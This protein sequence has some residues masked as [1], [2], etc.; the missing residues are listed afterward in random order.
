MTVRL[1]VIGRNG[2]LARSLDECS[3]G[4]KGLSLSFFGRPE[5]DLVIPGSAGAAIRAAHPHVVINAA[6]FTAVDLAESAAEETMR[7]N[8][9]GA[10]EVAAAAVE[11][12]AAVIQISTD[13]VFDG[14]STRP[15][16]E[17]D[18]TDPINVYGRSKLAGE[19]AV[20]SANP[21][22]CIVRTSWLFSPFG[23]NFVRTM[24]V[25]GQKRDV[26]KVVDDQRGNPTSALDLAQALL[27]IV[28]MLARNEQG[29]FGTW[30]LTGESA[31]SWC[32][33]AD[34]VQQRC[35]ARGLNA[36]QVV[37]I[38]TADWPTPAERPLHSV[39]DSGA[40]AHQFGLS[41]PDWRTALLPI[42]DRLID[43]AA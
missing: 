21:R 42:V 41:L 11:I 39:L 28:P 9:D 25:E 40:F 14:R 17:S 33:L 38:T 6:A 10:G 31:A 1:L 30:H 16:V 3:R 23:K 12:G 19:Q 20:R 2:Q 24:V 36:A 15:Y 27:K 35:R 29:T 32:E 7:V 18:P 22:H 5:L 26:I 8:C 37:P 4:M 34:T 43:S 13:Y